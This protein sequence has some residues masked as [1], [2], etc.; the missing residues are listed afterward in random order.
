MLLMLCP[1]LVRMAMIVCAALMLSICALMHAIADGRAVLPGMVM[2]EHARCFD[3]SEDAG[4]LDAA[5]GR[6]AM[7]Y[8][9]LQ[10]GGL[11]DNTHARQLRMADLN[12]A[13]NGHLKQH[14]DHAGAQPPLH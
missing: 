14:G 8:L 10:Q 11:A 7:P 13:H 3:L 2:V 6:G 4:Q 1:K 9:Q 5:S 12:G